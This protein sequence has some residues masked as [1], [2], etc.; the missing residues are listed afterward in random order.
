MKI[1]IWSDVICP[2]CGLGQHRLEAAIARFAQREHVEVVHRSFQ[3]D[4]S[5]PMGKTLTSRE[6]LT[7]KYRMSQA[8]LQRTTAHI[9]GLA[10]EDGLTPYHV[11]D[12]VVGNTR[13][14]HELLALARDRGLEEVAWKR[15]YH[16]YFGETRSLFDL[17]TLIALGVELGLPADDVREALTDGRYAQQVTEEG[18]LARELGADGVPFV[19]ID[20]ALAL[21]GAQPVATFL[22]AMEQAWRAAP[23]PIE[24][25][26]GVGCGAD[27][28]VVPV[29]E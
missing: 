9:E 13:L 20:R 6:L 12:N 18:E 26:E 1:E 17:D 21:S 24:Q 27:G 5:F 22:A 19:V 10:A 23:T 7:Q 14:A 8:Q 11:G 3:L 28:C 29:G 25:V 16:A 15:L 4:P 2:W